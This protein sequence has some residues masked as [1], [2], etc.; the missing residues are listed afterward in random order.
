MLLYSAD[1]AGIWMWLWYSDLILFTPKS[2]S[3]FHDRS[4][5]SWHSKWLL[6]PQVTSWALDAF[7]NREASLWHKI[8]DIFTRIYLLKIQTPSTLTHEWIECLYW[9]AHSAHS[10]MFCLQHYEHHTDWWA[11]SLSDGLCRNVNLIFCSSFTSSSEQLSSFSG[12]HRNAVMNHFV[13]TS[14]CCQATQR[15]CQRFG[16]FF[17]QLWRGM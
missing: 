7:H 11:D 5:I 3:S 4:S 1:W 12:K 17:T 2:L 15:M 9:Q 14:L 6:I 16:W 10:T 13:H 8:R